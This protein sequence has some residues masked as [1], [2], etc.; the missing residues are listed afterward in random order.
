[1][2]RLTPLRLAALLICA[3]SLPAAAQPGQTALSVSG[4]PAS[5]IIATSIAG[6]QP[7]NIVQAGTSYTVTAKKSAGTKKIVGQLSAPMPTGTTLTINLA[8]VIGSVS[9]GAVALDMTARDLVISVER[10]NATSA[11]ITYTFAATVAAGVVPAQTRT[12][13]FTLLNYP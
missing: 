10:E 6:N 1:M 4:P 5:M 2:S 8:A 7:T 12:V 3:A 11:A 13:I 9:T